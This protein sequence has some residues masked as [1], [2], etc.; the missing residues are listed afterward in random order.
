MGVNGREAQEGGDI[1][2][3]IVDLRCSIAE[4]NTPL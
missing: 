2:L 1:Y 3:L 4:T